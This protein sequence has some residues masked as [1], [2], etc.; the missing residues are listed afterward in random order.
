MHY[1]FQPNHTGATDFDIR[2]AES[3][4]KNWSR[5]STNLVSSIH[6]ALNLTKIGNIKI[7]LCKRININAFYFVSLGYIWFGPY[8]MLTGSNFGELSSQPSL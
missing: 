1:T 7:F 6:A 8:E 5:K 2:S 4:S 3:T